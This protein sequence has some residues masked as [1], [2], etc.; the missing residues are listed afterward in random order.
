MR[1][2]VLLLP[3][4]SSSPPYLTEDVIPSSLTLVLPLSTSSL[5]PHEKV[6]HGHHGY[7]YSR[8]R[9]PEFHKVETF[10]NLVLPSLDFPVADSVRWK[11]NKILM[12]AG[13]FGKQSAPSSEYYQL[14]EA[15]AGSRGVVGLPLTWWNNERKRVNDVVQSVRDAPRSGSV[16]LCVPIWETEGK[17]LEKFYKEWK[18]WGTIRGK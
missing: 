9:G 15:L 3:C 11:K 13:L 2:N 17:W 10:D 8:S 1:T 4:P 12:N 18:E 16:R 6:H 5:V 7:G 14:C